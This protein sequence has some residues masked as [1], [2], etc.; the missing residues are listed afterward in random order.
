MNKSIFLLTG[1]IFLSPIIN[2]HE[3][4]AILLPDETII[5]AE[6]ITFPNDDKVRPE[7]SDFKLLHQVIMSNNH[8]ER[9]ATITLNNTAHGKRIFQSKNIL[10]LFADGSRRFPLNYEQEFKAQQV[11]SLTLNFG[12][13]QFPI[14]RIIA[15]E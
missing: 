11:L 13:S 1:S 6:L 14:V 10:A 2:A 5:G 15:R 9:W 3:S 4:E 8:G 12:F 7:K